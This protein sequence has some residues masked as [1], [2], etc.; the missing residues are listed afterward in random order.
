[1]LNIPFEYSQAFDLALKNVVRALPNRP[2]SESDEEVVCRL[3]IDHP[4]ME[5]GHSLT[6]PDNRYTT[7]LLSAVS[8]S[9]PATLERSVPAISTT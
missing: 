7:V 3:S 2:A 8:E 5:T 1:M 4:V 6:Y 9:L